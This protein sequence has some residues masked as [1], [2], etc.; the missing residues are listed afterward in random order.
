MS[1]SELPAAERHRRIA[2][3]FTDLVVKVADW[4]AP[5]P[6]AGWAARDVVAHLVTW[7]PGFLSGG[8][9][10][11]PAGL[12]VGDHPRAAWSF[13]ADAV[14]GLLDDPAQA[15]T[16]FSHEHVGSMPA[17]EAIDR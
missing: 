10:T 1:L 6:V 16:P 12:A 4:D 17:G 11:I 13:H 2:G 14:Q 15:S 8:G 9:V 3:D 7:L 5:A